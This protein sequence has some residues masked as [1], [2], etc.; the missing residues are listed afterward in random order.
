MPDFKPVQI[1]VVAMVGIFLIVFWIGKRQTAQLPALRAPPVGLQPN[2]RIKPPPAPR[3]QTP[4]ASR[5]GTVSAPAKEIALSAE[6]LKASEAARKEFESRVKLKIE[7]PAGFQYGEVDYADD[8][9]MLAGTDPDGKSSFALIARQGSVSENEVLQ[10]I[11]ADARSLPPSEGADLVAI[12]KPSTIPPVEGS[13]LRQATW[14]TGSLSN[15]KTIHYV[16][17]PRADQAGTYLLMMSGKAEDLD[18]NEEYFE[19]LYKDIKAER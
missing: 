2:N 17:L 13:G 1:F 8:I 12:G 7:L 5:A 15:G 3:A 10:F 11:R 4:G 9:A 6:V 19:M 16:L 14:W 18:A